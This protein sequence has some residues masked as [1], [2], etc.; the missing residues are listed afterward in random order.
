M[1]TVAPSTRSNYDFKK[2]SLINDSMKK[3][4]EENNFQFNFLFCFFISCM[5]NFSI[6]DDNN[7]V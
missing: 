1:R 4:I 6:I 3:I 2:F 5:R 7:T